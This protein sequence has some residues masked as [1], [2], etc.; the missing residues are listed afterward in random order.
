MTIQVSQI[1]NSDASERSSSSGVRAAYLNQL[2]SLRQELASPADWLTQVRNRATALVQEQAMPSPQDEDWRFTDLSALLQ[3]NFAVSSPPPTVTLSDL[4][5]LTLTEDPSYR[6][7]FVNGVFAPQ[8]SAIADLPSGLWIGNLGTAPT[9]LNLPDF[10]AKQQGAEE[11]FTALNTAS[12]TDAAVVWVS[13]QVAIAAPIHLLMITAP[14]ATPEVLHPRCLV[15]AEPG[16]SL[17][18][19]EEYATVGTGTTLSNAVTELWLADSA[20]VNHVLVQQNQLTGFHVGKTAV[21]QARGSHYR[22]HPIT[23]GAQLSR[24]HLEVFSRG[25]Q[26]ETT[27]QALTQ[28]SGQQVADTHSAIAHLQP[29]CTSRQVHKCIVGDRAHAVF[30]GKICVAKAAQLTDAAQLSRNL[31]LSPRARIDTKPQLE[32]VADNVKCAHGATVSQ[33]DN[34]EIFYLQSRGL[35]R[36]AACDLLVYA[37][38]VDIFHRIPVASVRD[39]L[40]KRL[41]TAT[42]PLV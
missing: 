9:A 34:D 38:A 28:I 17:T 5:A 29:H 36:E 39:R 16:S 32:I 37:F 4:S 27:I 25:E 8:L 13:K 33:L 24:H 11:V 1:V 2:L 19:V 41:T 10:L 12:F 3:V 6:L 15:V 26:T 7:V 30:N 35:D 14:T 23:L 21:F 22:G 40:V 31:L 18:L 42:S 20:Q